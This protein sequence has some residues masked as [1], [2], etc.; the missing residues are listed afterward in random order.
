MK[1]GERRIAIC[2]HHVGPDSG[3]PV[4]AARAPQTAAPDVV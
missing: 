2:W 1:T 4:F 3:G